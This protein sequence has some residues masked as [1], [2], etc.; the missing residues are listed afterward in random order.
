INYQVWLDTTK[1]DANNKD[2]IQTVGITDNYDEAKL[3]VK[4]SD[5][6]AYD[7]KTGKDVTDKFNI[8][9]ANG[10]ITANLKDGFT[11][12]LGDAENTQIIDTTKFEFGRYYK[13]VIPA[14]VTDGAYDG[15]EIEN[16]AAQVVNYYNPTTKT[17]EKPNKPT[18][19]RVNNVPTAIELI[20]GKTLNGRQLKIKNL[21]CN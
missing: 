21:L 3:D 10:V 16:T 15:A 14:K 5:I 12:S 13:F 4:V 2:N 8:S 6:K 18:E 17:V 9:I 7:G 1:F 20:F 11:K 19:K